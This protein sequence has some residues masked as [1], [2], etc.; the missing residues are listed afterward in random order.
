MIRGER[1]RLRCFPIRAL[2][3]RVATIP[4]DG[5]PSPRYLD[6]QNRHCDRR[7]HSP[8]PRIRILGTVKPS[9]CSFIVPGFPSALRLR[10]SCYSRAMILRSNSPVGAL[11]LFAV[12]YVSAPGALLTPPPTLFPATSLLLVPCRCLRTNARLAPNCAAL[13]AFVNRH[14]RSFRTAILRRFFAPVIRFAAR[15][16][17]VP[18]YLCPPATGFRSGCH[19][20][21]RWQDWRIAFLPCVFPFVIRQTGD[22]FCL[23]L[24]P[25]HVLRFARLASCCCLVFFRLRFARLTIA[26]ALCFSVCESPNC[27]CLVLSP[28]HVLRFARLAIAFALY[29]LRATRCDSPDW[30]IAFALCFSVCDAPGWRMAFALCFSVCDSPDW[31]L[32]LPCVFP[33]AIRQAGE[34]LLPCVFPFVI[35]QTGELLLPCTFSE[36]RVAIRQTGDCFCLVFFRLR[37]ARLANCFCLVLS[38]S[39]VLRFARLA[40]AFALCFSVCDSPG[41]RVAVAL[42]VSESRLR[43]ARLAN[44]FCLVPF[45]VSFAN[46]QTGEFVLPCAFSRTPLCLFRSLSLL[47]E[48]CRRAPRARSKSLLITSGRGDTRLVGTCAVLDGTAATSND[49]TRLAAG[50]P[51]NAFRR[52]SGFH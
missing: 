40:I 51:R 46:R 18:G 21:T 35:R 27:F 7:S 33:F 5:S 48:T 6:L 29:F 14:R 49:G 19:V 3:L 44:C 41:W 1:T 15:A 50:P 47:S 22:C 17:Y 39:H 38:P 32:L 30:R 28:S 20:H 31:R 42:C 43:F 24:S 2:A 13:V 36:P 37:F 8:M 52:E 10:S 23:V 25:S 34:L 16:E 45:R 4:I 9:N 26:V 12:L 11:V